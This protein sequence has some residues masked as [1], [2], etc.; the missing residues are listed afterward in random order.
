MFWTA[1]IVYF[2][3][4]ILFCDNGRLL[5]DNDRRSGS[6]KNSS[7][8]RTGNNNI[9]NAKCNFC[10]KNIWFS[11]AIGPIFKII[12]VLNNSNCVL[13]YF[14]TFCDN[15]RLLCYYDRHKFTGIV[16]DCGFVRQC[17]WIQILMSTYWTDIF[18]M[19]LTDLKKLFFRIVSPSRALSLVR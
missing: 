13:S 14:D 11:V 5:W 17:E 4:L 18:L 6:F 1:L 19:I 12:D 3:I 2:L 10:S 9:R 15:G 8:L 16:A 7:R